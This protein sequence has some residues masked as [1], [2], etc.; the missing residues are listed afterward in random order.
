MKNQRK[1]HKSAW[2]AVLLT[3]DLMTPNE[4]RKGIFL[5]LGSAFAS[6]IDV[7]ALVGVVPL[8]GL[9]ID[10]NTIGAHISN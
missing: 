1:N 6:L 10:P 7:I 9:I 5:S 2:Q 3:W 8:V 4:R